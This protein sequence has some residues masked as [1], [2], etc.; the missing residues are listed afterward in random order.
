MMMTF[1]LKLKFLLRCTIQCC[2]NRSI[3]IPREFDIDMLLVKKVDFDPKLYEFNSSVWY[4][5]NSKNYLWGYLCLFLN[6]Y[7][8]YYS[9]GYLKVFDL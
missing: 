6:P 5:P 3:C 8:H 1:M 2:Y 4:L 7:V 9:I